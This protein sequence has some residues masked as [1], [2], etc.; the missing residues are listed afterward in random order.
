MDVNIVWSEQ[1]HDMMYAIVQ[2]ECDT[3]IVHLSGVLMLVLASC[4]KM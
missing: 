3:V 2:S 4:M 1:V